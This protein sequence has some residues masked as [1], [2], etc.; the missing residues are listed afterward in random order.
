[1]GRRSN[2]RSSNNR[3]SN[4]W[5][6]N[7][8]SSYNWRSYN[9]WSY[10]RRRYHRGHYNRSRYY[11]SSYNRSSYNRNCYNRNCYN[12]SSYNWSCNNSSNSHNI[13][14]MYYLVTLDL[15]LTIHC[16][17]VE[18]STLHLVVAGYYT[19]ELSRWSDVKNQIQCTSKSKHWITFAQA[20]SVGFNVM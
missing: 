14:T 19:D 8:R 6:S 10:N 3:S 18:H 11:R 12:R 5:S 20:H 2:I 15:D 7:N 17:Q 9:W 4:N 1:M 13:I 16:A